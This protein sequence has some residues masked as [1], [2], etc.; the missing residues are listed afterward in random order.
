MELSGEEREALLVK[1]DPEIRRAVERLLLHADTP[2][3]LLDHPAWERA[4]SGEQHAGQFT[5]GQQIGP[6]R[7]DAKIGAGGMGQVYRA[8]DLR[9][10]RI[11]AV[12]V[13]GA[14]FPARFEREAKAIAA[15]NHPNICQVYDVGPN[16]LVMEFV[17]GRPVVTS[18]QKPISPDQ[19]LPL[20]VQIAS[21]MQAAHAMGIIHRDLKPENILV[22]ASGTVKLLD[23]GLAKQRE[24][25]VSADAATVNIATTHVGMILG[26]PGYMSPEQAEGGTADARSDIFS[27]GT[28]LYEILSGARAFPG[29]SVASVLGA[30]LHREP[31]PLQPASALG[32]IAFKCLSKSPA[33]RYQSAAELLGALHQGEAGYRVGTPKKR[34]PVFVTA[35][36]LLAAAA[37]GLFLYRKRAAPSHIDSIAVLPFDIHSKD[38]D[39]DYIS[40]GI[41]D[42]INN[43]L[44][45]LPGLKVVPNSVA[46][47]YKGKAADFQKIGDALGVQTVL[48][49]RIAQRGDDLSIN[50]ELD[51]VSSG[52]QLWGQQYNRKVAELLEIQNDIAREVSRKL[53][54]QLSPED[55]Q[56]LTLGS[57]SN[58]EAYQAYLKGR[59]Y[60]Y[61]FTKD[62]FDKGIAFLNQAIALDPNYALAYSVLASNYI[63]QD[64]W[65][66]PPREAAPKARDLAT[67]AIALDDTDSDA[68]MSLA[69]ENH[70]YEWNWDAAEKEFKRAIELDPDNGDA[71]GYYS[72]FLAAMGRKEAAVN[73]ARV[74]ARIYPVSAGGNSNLGSVFVFNHQWDDAIK[75]LRGAIDLDSS[76]WFDHFFLGRAY[77]QK[78]KL[79]EAIEVFK[80]G[81]ALEGNTEL[82]GALGHAYAV[83]GNRTEAENVLGHMKEL[84]AQRYVAPYN[85]AI[86]YAGLGDKDA[87]FDWLTRAYNDRSYILAVYFNTDA[88]LD[89]LR[90]D[91]RFEELRR[92]INLPEPK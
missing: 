1:A 23:F 19:A 25:I 33:A 9:L 40:D 63:N 42:S 2:D 62:G 34:W 21:A 28:I 22:T 11:V 60:T 55:R 81:L 44:A 69:I 75:E 52:K 67:R 39:A 29:K 66:L 89:S 27:F 54:A 88:R 6:Y 57:T 56:K 71:R 5:P 49:G 18:G 45:R 8:T 35:A 37:A 90:N 78:G 77:E 74:Q 64:D 79:P 68:H 82:W 38:A 80:Q 51:D 4:A 76:S 61:L 36:I 59:Y 65:Y 24:E 48:S 17:D 92:K 85:F 43:S 13:T 73:E 86:V 70:W 87:A 91:P 53:R 10:N 14:E 58:Q 46:L 50:I 16:Y 32:A 30:I 72:W 83:S 20:A 31:D 26:T 7:I 41:S 12:K 3:S 47:R 84:S 15:L